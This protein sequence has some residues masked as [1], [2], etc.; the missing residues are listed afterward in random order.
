MLCRSVVKADAAVTAFADLPGADA[1]AAYYA[2]FVEQVCTGELAQA[3]GPL[4]DDLMRLVAA[5]AIATAQGFTPSPEGPAA[6]RFRDLLG[7]WL[8]AAESAYQ[9]W[10]R[11]PVAAGLVTTVAGHWTA[12]AAQLPAE[13]RGS[14]GARAAALGALGL[15]AEGLA[16]TL[17]TEI[18]AAR[19]YRYGKA[20]STHGVPLL[21]VYAMVNRPT[22]LDLEPE[23][24]LI[25]GLVESG[26]EVYLLDWGDPGPA[27]QARGLAEWI[28][29]TLHQVVKVVGGRRAVDVL[30]VC[31]GG[32]FSLLYAALEP[33]R[34]RRLVTMVTP[35]DFQTDDDLLS[36][37]ARG[38]DV[39]ML[40]ASETI[41]SGE[42]I[43]FIFQLLAPYRLVL[44]KYVDLLDH[45]ADPAWVARFRRMERWVHDGPDQ[46]RQLLVDFAR[47]FYKENRFMRGGLLLDG[48]PVE[49]SK[50]TLPILN[51]YGLEDHIVPPRSSQALAGLTASRRYEEIAV[52]TGHIGVF[53]STRAVGLPER[54]AH[55]LARR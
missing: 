39:G 49:L 22:I 32:V 19:L 8:V 29:G 27:E 47:A 23:R 25:R 51:I 20:G 15:P 5:S 54:I 10:A 11:S 38:L 16:R 45:A 9:Q 42:V 53:V 43:G 37:W 28:C 40:E 21:V 6:G 46:P 13:L 52:P 50:L 2:R 48:R 33:R 17:V 34:I 14:F 41:I 26:R 55:W 24:S 31:Q 36:Q 35:V 1:F 18:G 44:G 30:G 3:S 4:A 12:A 7:P